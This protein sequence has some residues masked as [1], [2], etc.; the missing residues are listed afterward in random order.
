MRN[1]RILIAAL[2]TVLF[3]LVALWVT[4]GNSEGFDSFVYQ[5]MHRLPAQATAVF[6]FITGAGDVSFIV[7]VVLLFLIMSAV[8]D[9]EGL[10][11]FVLVNAVGDALLNNALKAMFQ[12]PRPSFDH[13]VKAS[14]HSFPSG[15]TM[16]AVALYGFLLY[17]VW[18]RDMEPLQKRIVMGVLGVLILLIPLSRIYL[19]VHYAS[20]IV[21]GLFIA[22]AY[23]MVFL[24]WY[25]RKRAR[26]ASK[27]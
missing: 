11:F 5:T 16:I 13:L 2:C 17:V 23:L 22:T 19:G 12:R 4:S 9:L 25:D 15:H 8:Y 3:G 20:D 14:G 6:Q 21:G 18:K 26:A 1:K 27:R 24:M 10:G 7:A